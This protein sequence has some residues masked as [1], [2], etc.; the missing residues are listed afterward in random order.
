MTDQ[1]FNDFY[2][3]GAD[4]YG[5]EARPEYHAFLAD[6]PP[7][8]LCLDLACGQGRHAI[9]AARAGLRVHAVDYAE[10]AIRQLAGYAERERLPIDAECADIRQLDLKPD[11]YDAAILV[12]TLSHFD[13]G[14]LEPLVAM[15]RRGLKDMGQVFVEA[16]TTDDP[17]YRQSPDASETAAA[18]RHFFSPNALAALFDGFA[19]SAYREFVEDDLSHGPAHQHGVALLIGQKKALG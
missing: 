8:S 7:G 18:L 10:V 9:P 15:I 3:A 19:I 6:L 5:L 17:A 12:S 2:A 1:F 11:T 13:E 16:F 4:Y 14:D